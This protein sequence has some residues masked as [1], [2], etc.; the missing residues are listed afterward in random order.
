MKK[1]V[2]LS[3]NAD[4]RHSGL[5]SLFEGDITTDINEKVNSDIITDINDANDITI[6]M[7]DL[8]DN[9]NVPII[10]RLKPSTIKNL[11]DIAYKTRRS[12]NYVIQ[13]LLDQAMANVK[14][15]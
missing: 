8:V 2:N 4:K 12:R 10:A 15:K 13:K 5:D 11:D 1:V 14:L 6:E 7:N 3:G 9:I